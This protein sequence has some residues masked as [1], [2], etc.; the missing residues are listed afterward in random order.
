MADK[1]V[2]QTKFAVNIL[3]VVGLGMVKSSI[4][5]F[6]KNI[7]TVRWFRWTVYGMLGV[8]AVWTLSF[9]LTNLFTCYPVTPLIEF[10]YGN[11]CMETVPMWLSV[12]ITDLIVDVAILCM[13]VPMVLKL[14]LP[15]KER[16]AVLGMFMLGAT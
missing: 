1:V 14:H 11:K 15:W 5:I 3:A 2:L 12:V 13:P 6:Y 10:F 4:L 16:L 7:F 8:V 9:T